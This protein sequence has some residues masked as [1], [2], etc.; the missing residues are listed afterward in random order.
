MLFASLARTTLTRSA[1]SFS[2]TLFSF[3]G[4]AFARA[5]STAST[6]TIHAA[7][8]AFHAVSTHTHTATTFHATVLHVHFE[9]FHNKEDWPSNKKDFNELNHRCPTRI[10][11]TG[12]ARWKE[13]FE[14]M[15]FLYGMP[16][17]S[18]NNCDTDTKKNTR[19]RAT[20]LGVVHKNANKRLLPLVCLFS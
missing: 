10:C 20:H 6:F 5:T 8:A 16:R 7:S 9:H 15:Q 1:F 2:F 11:H 12:K 18:R 3:A 14:V 19:H 13:G 4:A 17:N